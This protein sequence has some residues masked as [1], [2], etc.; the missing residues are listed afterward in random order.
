MTA[1]GKKAAGRQQPRPGSSH[2][3]G[4]FSPSA[5]KGALLQ[6]PETH[7]KQGLLYWLRE[8]G[9][10][11]TPKPPKKL[12][13]YRSANQRSPVVSTGSSFVQPPRRIYVTDATEEKTEDCPV[14]V[15]N[16]PGFRAPGDAAQRGRCLPVHGTNPTW[17]SGFEVLIVPYIVRTRNIPYHH[18]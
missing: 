18:A 13:S 8:I 9:C 17:G 12:C 3:H 5:G 2:S 11:L 4:P 6:G 16:N 14:L 10:Q 15:V 1:Q 7:P